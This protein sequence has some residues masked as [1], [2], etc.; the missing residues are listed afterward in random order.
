[1]KKE[2]NKVN[3]RY[4]VWTLFGIIFLGGL[5]MAVTFVND[6]IINIPSVNTTNLNAT[7][8]YA[9][10]INASKINGVLHVMP[11]NGSDISAKIAL[12]PADK[13]I[14]HIPAGNY[15][16]SST[17]TLRNNLTIQGEG[18]FKTKIHGKVGSTSS[19][20]SML[21]AT[22]V[23]PL[24]NIEIRDLEIDG[25]EMN[26]SGAFSGT[27]KAIFV[28]YISHGKFEN[29]YLHDTPATCLGIDFLVDVFITGILAENCGNSTT[30]GSSGIGIGTNGYTREPLIITNSILRNN[31]NSGILIE[32]QGGSNHAT[33]V[34]IS[35][36]ITEYNNDGI[37]ISGTGEI[38]LSNILS[39]NNSDE[40]IEIDPGTFSVVGLKKLQLTN[41]QFLDNANNGILFTA[42]DPNVAE[43]ILTNN[44]V[45]RSGTNGVVL[46][47]NEVIF[48]NNLIE[49]NLEMGV[50][51]SR[52][53]QTISNNIIKGNGMQGIKYTF[54]GNRSLVKISDNIIKDNGLDED[55]TDDD[56]IEI[57]GSSSNAVFSECFITDNIIT[58]TR[59]QSNKTQNFG[60][61]F[62]A[63]QASSR[64]NCE[65]SGNY[66]FGN[67]NGAISENFDG[68]STFRYFNNYGSPHNILYGNLTLSNIT[69]GNSKLIV[70][71]PDGTSWTCSVNNTGS[72]NCV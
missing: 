33:S 70:N 71:S 29:L 65:I 6:N 60:L 39:F 28:Q 13:C 40:G 69:S 30:V 48:S 12:C 56:G 58:D 20:M 47:A 63:D 3:I 9:N 43:V 42:E 24:R 67:E 59:D 68:N 5:S 18:M 26:R 72:F 54:G 19:I 22:D 21:T 36:I 35:N 50:Q 34:V 51:L 27:R 41:S 57:S 45:A 31:Y 15:N 37:Y 10:N 61:R 52:G 55:G 11:N 66:L 64:L 32:E 49:D 23:N 14:V 7:N 38:T 62:R 44:I 4:F 53:N 2:K 16:I 17:I 46:V 8:I 1:M 25:I